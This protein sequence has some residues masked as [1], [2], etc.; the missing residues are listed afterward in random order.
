[1]AIDKTKL[2]HI[3]Q[4]K[5]NWEEKLE[6]NGCIK[7]WNN[8]MA[9]VIGFPS[10]AHFFDT[11]SHT[12]SYGILKEM[13]LLPPCVFFIIFCRSNWIYASSFSLLSIEFFSSLIF[14]KLDSC[15]LSICLLSLFWSRFPRLS[16]VCVCVC[17]ALHLFQT[18]TPAINP[19]IQSCRYWL[20]ESE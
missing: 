15:L 8:S 20:H 19:S 3:H 9:F 13:K 14:F 1:M 12:M 17:V 7:K 10:S 6:Q 16:A 11:P 5:K 4:K 18:T 2:P